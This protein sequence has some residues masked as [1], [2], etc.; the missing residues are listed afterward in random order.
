MPLKTEEEFK[1]SSWAVV[2]HLCQ[3]YLNAVCIKIK[4]CTYSGA[5]GALTDLVN[6][7]FSICSRFLPPSPLRVEPILLLFL[8]YQQHAKTEK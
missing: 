3:F 7:V 4:L 6:S 2:V 1:R 5:L 8:D